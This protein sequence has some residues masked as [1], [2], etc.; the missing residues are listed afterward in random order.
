MF[1]Q[2]EIRRLIEN[3]VFRDYEM[4]QEFRLAM[5]RLCATQLDPNDEPTLS[6]AIKDWLLGDVARIASLKHALIFQRIARHNARHVFSSLTHWLKLAGKQGLVLGLDVTRYAQAV[7][8]AERDAANYYLT[9]AALDAYEVLRQLIDGTDELESC[10]I[11]VIAGQEFL[12]DEQRG[13][14][15]YHALYQ[16]IADEVHDRYR[17]NPLA[18]LVRLHQGGSD[19]PTNEG[20]P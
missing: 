13:A 16:R 5:I 10:F 17:E 4:S 12:T 1:L 9:A 6:G 11:A 7:P 18:S 14:R 20:L 8:R 2:K 3:G 19:M 15:R